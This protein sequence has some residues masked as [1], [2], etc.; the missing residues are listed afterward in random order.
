MEIKRILG[1]L[2]KYQGAVSTPKAKI[3]FNGVLNLHIPRSIGTVVQIALRVLVEDIDGGW[4]F[5]VMES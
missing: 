3:V 1:Q 5:L 2:T 4:R